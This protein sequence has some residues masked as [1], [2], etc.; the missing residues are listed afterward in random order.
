VVQLRVTLQ[1]GGGLGETGRRTQGFVLLG[2]L[3]LLEELRIEFEYFWF[4][5][6]Y[7]LYFFAEGEHV[8]AVEVFFFY[9]QVLGLTQTIAKVA[10]VRDI[11]LDEVAFGLG[12]R[13]LRGELL[14][15]VGGGT[16]FTHF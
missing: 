9:M 13:R 15:G 12:G 6:P 16:S 4:F 7:G 8:R 3:E 11:V 5:L 14:V 2:L 10:G 1:V